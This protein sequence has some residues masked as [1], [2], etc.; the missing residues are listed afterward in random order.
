MLTHMDSSHSQS[1]NVLFLIL[2]AVGLFAALSYA[3]TKS[4]GGGKTST[5]TEKAQLS[6]GVIDSYTA[7]VNGGV[8][9]LQMR[10]CTTIDYKTPTQWGAED[11]KCQVFHPQ[12]GGVIW[13]DIALPPCSGSSCPVIACNAW[14]G[15]GAGGYTCSGSTI[16]GGSMDN[17]DDTGSA[18]TK[19]DLFIKN[20]NL[21]GTLCCDYHLESEGDWRVRN[22]APQVGAGDS[23]WT[24]G[25]SRATA[26][27]AQ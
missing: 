27:T 26:C 13:Q 2:I 11:H 19:C 21:T 9:R 23:G 6:Q 17:A 8:M 18:Q 20:N 24:A 4:S 12:G 5:T 15:G 3:I 22:G 1:G 7:A 25:Y 16:G 14:A 10:G